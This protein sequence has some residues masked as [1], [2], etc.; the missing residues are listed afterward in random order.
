MPH[1]Y[2][3]KTSE[4][5]LE[6]TFPNGKRRT[7]PF[8]Y[9]Q[10]YKLHLQAKEKGVTLEVERT[11]KEWIKAETLRRNWPF[12]MIPYESELGSK[13]AERKF[14]RRNIQFATQHRNI[15]IADE[16]GLGKTATTIASIIE[17][18]ITGS[19]LVVPPKTGCETWDKEL[20]RWLPE[21]APYDVWIVI[22]GHQSP[23]QRVDEL[24]RVVQWD[25]GKNR[26]G[27][28]QWVIVSPNY[29][30][31]EV[32]LDPFGNFVYDDDGQKVIK[33]VREALPELLAIDWAAIIV[34]EA[35]QT[36]SGAVG[37][38]KKQSKQRQGL[39]MLETK[40]N[41]MRIAISGTPFRGKP[42]N[43]WGILN[44]LYPA[45]YRSYW[46]WID[47]YFIVEDGINNSRVIG[48]P[49]PHKRLA[50]TA[51]LAPIM[52]R[53][54]KAEV[55]HDLPL[56]RYGGTPL[57]VHGMRGP[58]GVQ[59]EMYGSQLRAYR[60]MEQV[61]MTEL[62]EGRL[63]ANGI[64]AQTI[65]L[66]QFANSY[67]FLGGK[68]DIFFPTFPSN[69]FDWIVNFLTERGIDGKGPGVSKVLIASQF[70][71]Q[72]DLF[73][74]RLREHHKI[75]VFT[76]TGKTNTAERKQ[77]VDDFQRGTLESGEP[78]PDVFMIN[79][80]AGG[81][82]I[83]LDAAEEVIIIDQTWIPDDQEQVENRVHRISKP[84]NVTIWNLYS[85]NTVDDLWI[86]GRSYQMEGTVKQI[87]DG[88]R[89]IE[90]AKLLFGG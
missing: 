11:L 49:K 62:E 21:I 48:P 5:E 78:A 28:R 76:L 56:K 88:P 71:K 17:N 1:A 51:E 57:V 65:R 85:T 40:D 64:L 39:G 50:M 52:I 38:I 16:P 80:K 6:V 87:L 66:K 33:P 42:Q 32:A 22:G 10:T 44:W 67:G 2:M 24:I 68:D 3:K 55:A 36:L 14:Q 58:I 79:T 15:L 12:T 26:I 18:D 35:H 60:E 34:D 73:A 27:P 13:L 8:T 77:I 23:L 83:T 69:K 46:G 31:M 37:N 30:R 25:L 86:A 89:G 47:E 59:I 84:H 4:T 41:A 81:V 43:L 19:I 75:P 70:T 90:F 63:T 61:A 74:K 54:T 82:S 7:Y 29:L 45:R 9:E 53:N 20:T 72:I